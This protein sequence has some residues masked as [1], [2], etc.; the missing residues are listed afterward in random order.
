MGVAGAQAT[1][2]PSVLMLSGQSS[3]M[4]L[5]IS[6]GPRGFLL[7]RPIGQT[8]Q[9]GCWAQGPWVLRSVWLGVLLPVVYPDKASL[10]CRSQL[11]S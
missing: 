10:S 9:G 1:L 7:P 4:T 6:S 8:P 5:A 2:M 11:L 3:G